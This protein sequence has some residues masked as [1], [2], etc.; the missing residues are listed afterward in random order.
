MSFIKLTSMPFRFFLLG[1]SLLI[2]H[3]ITPKEI[4]KQYFHTKEKLEIFKVF[5]MLPHRHFRQKSFYLKLL[6]R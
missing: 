5:S 3:H 1:H 6:Q 2:T 4:Y